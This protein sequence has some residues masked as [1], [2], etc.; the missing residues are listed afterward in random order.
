M[1]NLSDANFKEV[2]SN[3]GSPVVVDFWADWC[4][5]CKM[6]TPVLEE[7][8]QKYEGKLKIV[9][10]NVDENPN[11]PQ[12][13]GITGIPTLIVFK[14]GEAVENI[15]GALPKAQLEEIFNKHI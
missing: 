1:E 9:K 5:P 2:I 3:S 14:N 13:F 11:T 7:L 6:I 8:S 15:V 10:L 12:K 4:M